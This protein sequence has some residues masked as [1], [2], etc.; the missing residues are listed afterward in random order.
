MDFVSEMD[1]SDNQC[2]M[3]CKFEK[4]MNEMKCNEKSH[5]HKQQLKKNQGILNYENQIEI[6]KLILLSQI[7]NIFPLNIMSIQFEKKNLKQMRYR[8]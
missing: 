2:S 8:F 6:A 4:K 5:F 1:Y 7:A 3:N